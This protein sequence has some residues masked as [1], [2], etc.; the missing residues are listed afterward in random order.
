M[1]LS[2]IDIERIKN[3]VITRELQTADLYL[4]YIENVF[5]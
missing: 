1:P 2:Q 5:N 3:I 4:Q